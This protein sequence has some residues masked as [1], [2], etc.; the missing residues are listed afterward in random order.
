MAQ[1]TILVRAASGTYPVVIG[2]E[3]LLRIQPL[4]AREE[5][6]GSVFV[7]SSPRVWGLWGKEVVRGLRGH[8]AATILF[9]DAETAKALGS[10]ERVCRQLV[11]AGAD[12]ESV[13]VA[14]GGGV[15][16]DLAG[17]VASTFM[18]GVRLV[19][20]PTTL[21]AQVDSA[22][23]GKTGV[24]LPEGKNLIGSFYQPRLVI[25][26]P[27]L[28]ATLP[29]RKFRS[30]L[31]E[32]IKYGVIADRALFG[33]LEKS[34]DSV[35]DQKPSPLE[36]V[37]SRC[38]AAKAEVVRQD[39]REAGVRQILNFGHTLGHALEAVTGYEKFMHGEAVA[40]GMLAATMMAMALHHM[41]ESDAARIVRLIG[42]VGS[43]PE[44]GGLENQKILRAMKMDKKSRNGHLRWVLPRRIGN[45]DW[46]LDVPEAL[47]RKAL[48]QLPEIYA[49]S[50][51]NA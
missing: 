2:R 36:L 13:I 8:A 5:L 29:E 3:N 22:V 39:E 34:L 30:G 32:V 9:D 46:G 10:V 42:R 38:V 49:E 23:G 4:L 25:S 31:Y 27:Q 18:R 35:L 44:L 28:L 20:V 41:T 16:G 19:H 6:T 14:L 45:A 17:F 21:M 51:P 11:R 47:L 40:W 24:N 1:Q 26:D 15:V 12:R 43:L 7:L 48:D 37:I 33:F 50:R